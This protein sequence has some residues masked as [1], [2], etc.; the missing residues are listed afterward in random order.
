MAKVKLLDPSDVRRRLD[1]YELIGEIAT[2]GMATVFLARLGGVGGFQ[3]FVAIKRLHPHLAAEAE[4]VEMFL[5]EAR[6]AAGIHH[7][8]VVPIL[9]V[10][11]SDSGY[12]LVMEY[13]EGDTLAR[14]IARAVSTGDLVPRPIVVRIML[15][16]L[17]G[18]HAAHELADPGGQLVGLVHRDVSPQNVLV[19]VDG[20]SRITD[21]GVARATARL[22]TTRA[23]QLKGKL[24][25]MS[26]EQTKGE[27]IDRRAD[28]FSMGIL[29]W[30]ALVGRRLFKADNEAA[31][32]SRVLMDKIPLLSSVNPAI[33]REFDEVSVKALRREARARYQTAAEMAD[34]LER[35]ARAA[36]ATSHDVGVASPREVAAYVQKVIGNEVAA[37][38]ESVRA[39]LAQSEPNVAETTGVRRAMQHNPPSGGGP[40]APR[41]GSSGPPA[42]RSGSSG[43]PAPRSGAW[44]PPVPHSDA[45]A[46]ASQDDAGHRDSTM[47]F[48]LDRPPSDPGPPRG[49]PVNAAPQRTM[50]S[51]ASTQRS[52]ADAGPQRSKTAVGLGEMRLADLQGA[53][54]GVLPEVTAP[55]RPRQPMLE[56]RPPQT[57]IGLGPV[58][59]SIGG[60]K[61]LPALPPGPTRVVPALPIPMAPPGGPRDA[62]SLKAL[63]YP[64]LPAGNPSQE[65]S[66]LNRTQMGIGA[67]DTAHPAVQAPAAYGAPAIHEPSPEPDDVDM[68]NDSVATLRMSA[69]SLAA[70]GFNLGRLVQSKPTMPQP[71]FEPQ[72]GAANA[73]RPVAPP[74]PK[75]V[76][77]PL[78]PPRPSTQVTTSRMAAVYP[79]PP[80]MQPGSDDPLSMPNVPM[81]RSRSGMVAAI[82]LGFAVLA[83][84]VVWLKLRTTAPTTAPAEAPTQSVSAEP[85]VPPVIATDTPSAAAS[86]SAAPS[87]SATAEPSSAPTASAAATVERPSTP[88][89]KAG[90]RPP[91]DKT[92][93]PDPV[94]PKDPSEDLTNPYH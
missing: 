41:S 9:E 8:H 58:A 44:G 92:K 84:V 25:Y 47:K 13:I 56:Q 36:A 12:Y 21:F 27:D 31:T 15:D 20:S 75:T 30:E 63:P 57:P 19:G 14:I 71:L 68:D 24:A 29:L 90:G 65:S 59:M 81:N 49:S 45:G 40:P 2:G 51:N 88:T 74:Q 18:L 80:A 37:Q 73:Q 26:P 78:D 87:S 38:R 60:V 23:G 6:L 28:L 55:S 39:W 50:T 91:P 89:S 48:A 43:P 93:K 64:A 52:A 79:R 62:A 3:R 70:A 86:T 85:I 67:S 72:S 77:M 34:A 33:P 1:R 5:D 16:S 22:S 53:K 32:I 76:I 10:G 11:T 66:P 61:E 54:R 4:F 83:G 42:P 7:P 69:S 46:A 17:A 35:A 82:I 94:K